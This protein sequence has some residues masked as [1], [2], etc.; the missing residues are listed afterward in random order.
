[1]R[2]EDEPEPPAHV[3]S[4]DRFKDGVIPQASQIAKGQREKDA[5]CHPNGGWER[6]AG[7]DRCAPWTRRYETQIGRA[8]GLD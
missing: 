5:T 4:A 3:S 2:G 6:D 7:F 1:M 8:P